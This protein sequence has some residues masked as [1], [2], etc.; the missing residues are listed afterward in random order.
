M[1]VA[2]ACAS[3][4]RPRG[5]ERHAK[6]IV[7]PPVPPG[8]VA[9][10]GPLELESVSVSRSEVGWER[11]LVRGVRLVAYDVV[12]SQRGAACRG[13]HVPEAKRDARGCEGVE[14]FPSTC[15]AGPPMRARFEVE[16]T[17]A[18]DVAQR[19]AGD[20]TPYAVPD[21][22]DARAA[23][24]NAGAACFRQRNKL[25]QESAWTSVYALTEL[26]ITERPMH[27]ETNAPRL[28]AALL[29]KG[30]TAFCRDD[31]AYLSGRAGAPA[32]A[33]NEPFDEAGL[34]IAL[35]A[36]APLAPDGSAGGTRRHPRRTSLS[37]RRG[38]RSRSTRARRSRPTARRACR[39]RR[40]RGGAST[41][42][43][44]RATRRTRGPIS[45]C[46]S[47]VSC[48]ASSIAS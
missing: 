1:V 37:T 40:A 14:T 47:A 31:G 23:L 21:K 19:C 48:S 42:S 27:V 43:G 46:R 9:A 26:S 24:T 10:F 29:G 32:S 45:W 6:T 13:P 35:D 39:S 11:D 12:V 5:G 15:D 18:I 30:A 16:V 41:I 36:R 28:L 33:T 44:R 8:Y 38:S 4:Q 7:E 34:A 20:A 22:G 2:A 25:R 17:W 3:A